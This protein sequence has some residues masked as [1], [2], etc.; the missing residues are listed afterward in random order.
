MWKSYPK[1]LGGNPVS[2]AWMA[3]GEVWM[4][5]AAWSVAEQR[6]VGS[7]KLYPVCCSAIA[8][9]IPAPHSVRR[10]ESQ[11][12]HFWDQ[13]NVSLVFSVPRSL[14]THFSF[15]THS[16]R[17][18]SP[19]SIAGVSCFALLLPHGA[20]HADPRREGGREGRGNWTPTVNQRSFMIADQ[21]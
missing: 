1:T 8:R 9:P 7:F 20:A 4:S 13:I 19:P 3:Q 18:L 10:G 15:S 6:N 14:W 2:Q 17:F 11:Q 16:L 12:N 21:F 5:L